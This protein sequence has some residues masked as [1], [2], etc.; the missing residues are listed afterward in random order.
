M[1]G[2]KCCY[3]SRLLLKPPETHPGAGEEAFSR[4][5]ELLEHAVL[6]EAN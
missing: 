3:E 6:L 2:F 4:L 1:L 5:Q